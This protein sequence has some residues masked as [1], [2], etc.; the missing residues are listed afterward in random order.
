M[1]K[2]D[3]NIPCDESKIQE[4][5]AVSREAF[6]A[7]Q[8]AQSLSYGEF[9]Y[10]QSRYIKKHW[11]LLQGA[12]LF[13]VCLLLQK[14]ESSMEM[15]RSLGG[16]AP[17]FV[18]FLLPEL[19]KNRG[20]NATEIE[21]TTFYTLRQVYAARFVLFAG[22]DLLLLT[23]FFCGAT[24]FTQI[25]FWDML[26]QFLLPCNVACCICLRSLYGG[27][28]HSEPL[29]I[30]LCSLWCGLWLAIVSNERIY[31]SISLPLWGGMLA[32]SFACLAYCVGRGQKTIFKNW[33]ASA[34]WN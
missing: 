33:E 10:Q 8:A 12:L 18:I 1:M 24:Y 30:L 16:A 9:L 27:R 31:G 5:I 29:C 26:I 13:L 28:I 4:T 11:W 19:W 20:N 17:L 2:Y 3:L 32:M 21:G 22:V 34:S 15:R 14:T 7:G 6:L 25:S 23:V